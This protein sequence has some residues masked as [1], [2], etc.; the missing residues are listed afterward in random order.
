MVWDS[1]TSRKN[2][3]QVGFESANSK[4]EFFKTAYIVS[5]HL[6]LNQTTF[7]IVKES[8]LNMMK[9]SS[10]FINAARAELVE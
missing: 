3:V 2:V 4:E 1:D 8:D 9:P 6:R 5:L 7:E 10:V